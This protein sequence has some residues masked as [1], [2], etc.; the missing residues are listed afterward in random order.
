MAGEL[1]TKCR[2]SR[3]QKYAR[4]GAVALV[5]IPV[6]VAGVGA[7]PAAAADATL[8]LSDFAG[9]P[10][11]PTEFDRCAEVEPTTV[12]G[13]VTVPDYTTG[14][15]ASARAISTTDSLPR[16]TGAPAGTIA[17]EVVI[18]PATPAATINQWIAAAQA[19]DAS[20]T[21]YLSPGVTS[22]S[23]SLVIPPGRPGRTFTLAGLVS[24][25]NDQVSDTT[26]AVLQGVEAVDVGRPGSYSAIRGGG[27]DVELRHLEVRLFGDSSKMADLASAAPSASLLAS[28]WVVEAANDVNT[29]GLNSLAA[30]NTDGSVRWNMN[31]NWIHVNAGAGVRVGD[32]NSV[33]DSCL[34]QNGQY[35][36]QSYFANDGTVA[37]NEIRD[38]GLRFA[39]RLNVH[40]PM[41]DDGMSGGTKFWG[42]RNIRTKSNLVTGNHGPGIWY[43]TN[44]FD[45]LID[46]NWIEANR[47]E[48][49][50]Y[51]TSYNAIV[52]NNYL[53]NNSVTRTP[54][55]DIRTDSSIYISNSSGAQLY[56]N[57]GGVATPIQS[58]M[59]GRI[60]VTNNF[61][62]AN[63]WPITIF[64]RAG[65]FCSSS[66]ESS[67]GS[68]NGSWS[69]A[70]TLTGA[71]SS[72]SA[73]PTAV[74]NRVMSPLAQPS[75]RTGV[76]LQYA[77]GSSWWDCS[78][79]NLWWMNRGETFRRCAWKTNNVTVTNNKIA[80][81]AS[82]SS[83]SYSTQNAGHIIQ[84]A[85]RA[86]CGT[87]AP[88]QYCNYPLV[89]SKVVNGVPKL[90]AIKLT[91][92]T[93]DATQTFEPWVSDDWFLRSMTTG[94]AANVVRDN[95]YLVAD[96]VAGTATYS[97]L[98]AEPGIGN[99][100]SST[101]S[102]PTTEA[103]TNGV[104]SGGATSGDNHYCRLL[105][106]LQ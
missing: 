58:P 12:A 22:L 83:P 30:V 85:S 3:A 36:V 15:F 17:P 64:H 57:I 92:M 67:G 71:R 99:C 41:Q 46:N 18:P 96:Q 78:D 65:R 24:S 80:L 42:S 49:I 61:V 38:N 37:T 60:L 79:Q 28:P 87:T 56:E 105:I 10:H 48:G 73:V 90:L 25:A 13:L 72:M 74:S 97:G 52:S 35:G 81:P 89:G 45:S 82:G 94:S 5:F 4:I 70:C 84:A 7:Q 44:N 86:T 21:F 40:I 69:G 88:L 91:G 53:R 39:Y 104:W 1:K 9:I 34:A 51:E 11:S 100:T 29:N 98:G 102:N 31:H 14:L 16:V 6:A 66:L 19:Q 54:A 63:K 2:Q 68:A 55:D 33:T 76:N 101:L 77:T 93:R 47:R 23:T 59:S 8:A 20:H 106:D 27:S 75:Y 43:D 26:H 95:Q 50:M 32:F 62:E 103:V